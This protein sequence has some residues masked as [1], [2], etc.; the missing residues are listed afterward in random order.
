MSLIVIMEDDQTLSMLVSAVLRKNGHVVYTASD[1]IQGLDLVRKLK[2]DVV[3]SDVQMPGLDGVNML[4]TLRG[5]AEIAH[6][7]VILLTSLGTRPDVRTGM[8]SGADDYLTKP[9]LPIE[10]CDAVDA[11]LARCAVRAGLQ[12]GVVTAAVQI[13]LDAQREDLAGT[14]ERRLFQELGGEKWPGAQTA[15]D[16]EY[17]D[18]TVLYVDLM[19]QGLS[20]I[21]TV[22][23]LTDA[24]RRAL[25]HASDTLHLFGAR[26]IH[27]LG[28]A[29]I[30]VFVKETDT[31]SVNHSMRAVRSALTLAKSVR[32]NR[33]DLQNKYAGKSFPPFDVGVGLH[34][35]PVTITKIHDPMHGSQT[36]IAPVGET[37]NV[38]SLLQKQTAALGWAVSCTHAVFENIQHNVGVDQRA[39]LTLRDNGVAI[40]AIEI[41]T[42]NQAGN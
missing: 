41:T 2:P 36:L 33:H 14:Y 28:E 40:Q 1:G 30:A 35:G 7:P 20:E 37:I 27:P 32:Q 3:V 21:L 18:A 15:A 38:A 8:T 9:F 42:L 24:L 31:E 22:T 11:Q 13:A 34:S 26:H 17:D 5:E 12:D 25:T 10:L 16:E 29:L 6:T 39:D 19:G 4:M 23:E